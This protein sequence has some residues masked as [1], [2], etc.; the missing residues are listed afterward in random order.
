MIKR[1][2]GE[3]RTRRVS[4]CHAPGDGSPP[5]HIAVSCR[6]PCR[7][8]VRASGCRAPGD[9]SPPLHIAAS[10]REPYRVQDRAPGTSPAEMPEGLWKKLRGQEKILKK[11]K[12]GLAFFAEVW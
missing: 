3:G 5:L 12:I 4:G 6:E 8:Q 10:C 9:G 1:R 2:K 7:V 11:V